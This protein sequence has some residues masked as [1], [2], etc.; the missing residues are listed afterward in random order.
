MERI[1]TAREGEDA[2]DQP[3][4]MGEGTAKVRDREVAKQEA[5]KVSRRGRVA[6]D[7][8]P[9]AS[10]NEHAVLSELSHVPN[11]MQSS[12][13]LRRFVEV[14][15]MRHRAFHLAPDEVKP[16][17]E[18]H[19]TEERKIGREPMRRQLLRS[20]FL[21]PLLRS[22]AHDLYLH[23]VDSPEVVDGVHDN[24]LAHEAVEP[25]NHLPVARPHHPREVV[26]AQFEEA[27]AGAEG[28]DEEEQER[29]IPAE[30]FD[31]PKEGP[32]IGRDDDETFWRFASRRRE[33]K[34]RIVL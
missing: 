22:G 16:H 7:K 11:G 1:E 27:I 25:T 34:P 20:A 19:T 4:D 33:L 30:V 2:E 3:S 12:A 14:V 23:H 6:E 28:S 29:F 31:E 17:G 24:S 5:L 8:S 26:H 10:D 13:K 9:F 15:H 21:E 18:S 32:E